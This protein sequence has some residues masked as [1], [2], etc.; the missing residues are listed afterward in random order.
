M[1]ND[2]LQKRIEAYFVALEAPLAEL[3]TAHREEFM[4]ETR[5]HLS[6]MVE[7]KRADGLGEEAAWNAAMDEFGEPKEVGRALW[8]QWARSGQLESEG[9]PVSKREL[10]RK[11]VWPVV[12]GLL[13]YGSMTLLLS[14]DSW[15]RTPFFALW[16]IFCFV[17]GT[18]RARRAGM[19]WT[20]AN[21]AAA[22]FVAL[23]LALVIAQLKWGE[24]SFGT[25]LASWGN[26]LMLGCWTFWWWLRQTD[27]PKRPWKTT[28]LYAQNPVA[29]EQEYRISPLIG[30]TV[31]SAMGF[32]SVLL[33]GLQF[34]SPTQTSLLGV[35]HL[36]FSIV[37]G[38]WIYRRR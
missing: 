19:Q 15:W 32:I 8:K 28:A 26:P 35:A 3:P 36:V 13:A 16:S 6:A 23:Q 21:L 25:M 30:W 1:A 12:F 22:V 27:M 9:E 4:A 37:G 33:L 29:V 20:P 5:A 24:S 38:I 7:A 31:G 17:F 11:F 18:H 10:A 14:S 2:E 34:F